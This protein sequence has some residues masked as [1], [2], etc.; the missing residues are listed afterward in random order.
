MVL[1]IRLTTS[2]EPEA[3]A[4]FEIEKKDG[5]KITTCAVLEKVEKIKVAYRYRDPQDLWV[6]DIDKVLYD[7]SECMPEPD[8]EEHKYMH[9]Y[10][11]EVEDPCKVRKNAKIVVMYRD[12][13]KKEVCGEYAGIS[14]YY[15]YYRS[16]VDLDPEEIFSVRLVSM[17]F[18]PT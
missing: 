1:E 11:V 17:G 2:R 7:G 15:V 12:G 4:M 14:A 9:A 16:C 6:Y 13:T 8:S 3:F 5:S 10:K 18:R